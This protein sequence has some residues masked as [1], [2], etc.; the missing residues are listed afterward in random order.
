M[1]GPSRKGADKVIAK[2][3]AEIAENKFLDVR[4]DPGPIKFHAFAKEYLE[5]AKV[6]YKPSSRQRELLTLRSAHLAPDHKM[7][8]VSIL[9]QVMSQN[10]PQVQA[11]E[12]KVLEF[13]R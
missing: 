6:N 3:K 10:P 13:K 7:R 2:K 11:E 8:A 4:K 5:C 9:D 12:P 1:I